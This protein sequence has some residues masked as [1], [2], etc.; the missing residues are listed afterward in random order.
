MIDLPSLKTIW[1][2]LKEWNAANQPIADALEAVLTLISS[3]MLV[4]FL[5]GFV[6]YAVYLLVAILKK[7]LHLKASLYT[8]LQILSLTLFEKMPITQALAQLPPASELPNPK[9]HP[10]LPGF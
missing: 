8:L 10:C 6:V 2:K 1:Q 3:L 7:R 9:N 4:L 5:G